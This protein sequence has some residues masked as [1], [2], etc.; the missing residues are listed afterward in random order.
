M[1]TLF[2]HVIALLHKERD[3]EVI[4]ILPWNLRYH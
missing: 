2:E 4:V 1:E 3:L